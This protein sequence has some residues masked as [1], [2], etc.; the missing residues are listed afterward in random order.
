MQQIARLEVRFAL[1]VWLAS[2]T[3]TMERL[4]TL[5]RHL[6]EVH[7]RDEDYTQQAIHE[8]THLA[9]RQLQ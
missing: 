2:E 6:C 9:E 5:V 8:A 1:K 7:A 4:E 3:R